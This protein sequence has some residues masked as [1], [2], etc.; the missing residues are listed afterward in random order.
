MAADAGAWRVGPTSDLCRFIPQ[1]CAFRRSAAIEPSIFCDSRDPVLVVV[2]GLDGKAVV[3]RLLNPLF[4]SSSKLAL[5]WA[6]A[7]LIAS[8]APLADSARIAVVAV[9][10]VLMLLVPETT[11]PTRL[12]A[13]AMLLPALLEQPPAW[14]YVLAGGLLAAVVARPSPTERTM[15]PL[16]RIQRRLEWY[17]RRDE[18]AEIVW[19]HSPEMSDATTERIIDLF[20]VTDAAARVPGSAGEIVAMLDPLKLDH[21]GLERRIRACAEGADLGIGWA[22]FPADGVTLE[23]LFD[24]AHDAAAAKVARRTERIGAQPS[25]VL[26]RL[27]PQAPAGVPAQPSSQG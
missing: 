15:T 4:S 1:S 23:V 2:G 20:R 14:S 25:S 27:G 24:R 7:S 6:S 18:S 11:R 13:V 21:A 10:A 5:L 26:S 3:A 19:I 16:E 17:R 12:F 22:T 8:V 9:V